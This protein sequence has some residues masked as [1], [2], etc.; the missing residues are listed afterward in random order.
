MPHKQVIW[1]IPGNTNF[2]SGF[3]IVRKIK[4]GFP[5]NITRE[6]RGSQVK[7]KSRHN[8][9]R[10]SSICKGPVA[11]RSRTRHNEG[12]GSKGKGSRGQHRMRSRIHTIRAIQIL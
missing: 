9:G 3:G 2:Q 4:E 12:G 11:P 1:N 10:G 5:E 7:K 6:L 8:M